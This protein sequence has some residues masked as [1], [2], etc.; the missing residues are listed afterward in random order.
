MTVRNDNL[1][2]DD[3]FTGVAVD[4]EG[5]F[6]DNNGIVIVTSTG[7]YRGATRTIQVAVK[8]IGIPPFPGAVNLA[9]FRAETFLGGSV[10]AGNAS[11]YDIDGRDYDRSGTRNAANPNKLGIQ[12]QPGT[13]AD[14]G[15]T[16]EA[17]VEQPFDDAGICT[18]GDCSA[19]TKAANRAAR[20]GIVK[21]KDQ[22]TGELTTGASAIGPDG[23]LTPASHVGFL[24]AGRLESGD[25]D[26]S[27]H[28][29]LP[30]R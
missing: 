3:T 8:R 7:T 11:R 4:P 13:Q 5:K 20:L 14:L 19:A 22:T 29:G 24:S 28:P 23:A 2:S 27:E 15:I 10:N 26:S 16:Y 21:G 1:A 6:T 9:G 17:R 18:G 30:D 12:V 25:P